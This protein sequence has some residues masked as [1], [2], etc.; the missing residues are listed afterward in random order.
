MS[1]K[2]FSRTQNVKE[3]AVPVGDINIICKK[4]WQEYGG[5]DEQQGGICFCSTVHT[6]TTLSAIGLIHV[7][8]DS[9]MH[10]TACC[11]Y[12]SFLIWHK[13]SVVAL[14]TVCVCFSMSDIFKMRWNG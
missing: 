14:E 6:F 5:N 1:Y 8:F 3:H 11:L 4:V 13:L 2:H 12:I 10:T 7:I 9:Y